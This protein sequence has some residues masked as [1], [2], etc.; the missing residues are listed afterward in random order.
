MICEEATSTCTVRHVDLAL[1]AAFL[2]GLV[3]VKKVIYVLTIHVPVTWQGCWRD[4]DPHLENNGRIIFKQRLSPPLYMYKKRKKS[5]R[6]RHPEA[7]LRC[8]PFRPNPR[9]GEDSNLTNK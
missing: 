9:G 6:D 5:E 7:P 3:R 1:N 8:R 4:T 2:V